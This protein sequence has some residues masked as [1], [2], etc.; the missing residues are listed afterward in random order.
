MSGKCKEC[1]DMDMT[2]N[3]EDDEAYPYCKDNG[4][5][6]NPK[7]FNPPFHYCPKE[8]KE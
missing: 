5:L 8:V 4:R 1:E 3:P 7:T 2:I 6:I